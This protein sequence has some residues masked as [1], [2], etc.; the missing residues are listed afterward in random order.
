M[1]FLHLRAISHPGTLRWGFL[2]CPGRVWPPAP[3]PHR[4]LILQTT[5][6]AGWDRAPG[7]L[8]TLPMPTGSWGAGS[9]PKAPPRSP[10]AMY[11]LPPGLCSKA[12]KQMQKPKGLKGCRSAAWCRSCHSSH[13]E[14]QGIRA[15]CRRASRAAA[16]TVKD[17][18]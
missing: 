12:R 14:L 4:D 18:L 7:M 13:S 5:Q 16:V 15:P 9:E 8:S 10:P 3:P 11:P 6:E 1:L 17:M 2:P